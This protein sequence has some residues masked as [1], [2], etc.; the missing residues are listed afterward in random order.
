[1]KT[2]EKT[3][4]AA[5]DLVLAIY[6]TTEGFHDPDLAGQLR[7][8]AVTIASKLAETGGSDLWARMPAFEAARLAA[9]E[10]RLLLDVALD[11]KALSPAAAKP[12]YKALDRVYRGIRVD[13]FQG[14]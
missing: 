2:A 7:M 11:L 4:Q 6:R 1:M 14:F 10:V 13:E 9:Q 12:L 5:H 8:S 3:W